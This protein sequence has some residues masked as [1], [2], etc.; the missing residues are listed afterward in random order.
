MN[1]NDIIDKVLFKF[2][3]IVKNKNIN[4]VNLSIASFV[5]MILSLFLFEKNFRILSSFLC[6]SAYI[7]LYIS[8]SLQKVQNDKIVNNIIYL[9]SNF[10]FCLYFM[11]LL[12]IAIKNNNIKIIIFMLLLLA[13]NILLFLRFSIKEALEC[14][15]I[16][17]SDNFYQK[18]YNQLAENKDQIAIKFY[19]FIM[20]CLYIFYKSVFK[21]FNK[22]KFHNIIKNTPGDGIYIIF[23][24]I[25]ILFI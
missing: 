15:D 12:I 1:K 17:L 23:L 9:F 3:P 8:Q 13:Y 5:C 19:L 10:L 6:I 20:N 22:D 2:I 11:Y 7:F 25:L 18:Y 24:S 16:T 21:E 14:H 4:S